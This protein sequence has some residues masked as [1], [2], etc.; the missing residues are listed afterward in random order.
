M[1]VGW[2]GRENRLRA[3]V[4]AQSHEIA[5]LHAPADAVD[6]EAIVI[7]AAEAQLEG[8]VD[9]LEPHIRRGQIVIHTSIG[10]GVQVLDPLEVHGAVAMAIAHVGADRW[11]VTTSEELAQGIAEVLRYESGQVTLPKTDA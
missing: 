7:S 11:V 8:L 5:D 6:C 3:L 1:R 10:L 9:A 2:F 4:D